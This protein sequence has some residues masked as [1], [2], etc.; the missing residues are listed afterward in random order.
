VVSFQARP[1]SG[2]QAA[3]LLERG[4][5]SRNAW[6]AIRMIGE[7]AGAGEVRTGEHSAEREVER[8]LLDAAGALQRLVAER[9]ALK[10]RVEAQEREL[11]RLQ[12]HVALFHDSYR[13]LTSEFIAQ[14]Q[15]IDSAVSRFVG[16][17]PKENERLKTEP[18][19]RSEG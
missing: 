14:S 18:G 11:T 4:R 16:A 2:I 3:R 13:R 8:L 9:D 1:E 15:L 6:N 17:E 5:H 12:E 19:A 10:V 7:A